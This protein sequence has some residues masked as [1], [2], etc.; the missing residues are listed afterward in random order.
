MTPTAHA[1]TSET[2]KWGRLKRKVAAGGEGVGLRLGHISFIIFGYDSA[3]VSFTF[4]LLAN[5]LLGVNKLN[6]NKKEMASKGLDLKEEALTISHRW[7]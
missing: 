3:W 4:R 6:K 2:M 5:K 7:L 1:H